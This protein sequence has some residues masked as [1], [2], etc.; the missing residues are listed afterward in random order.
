MIKEHLTDE[1]KVFES[2]GIRMKDT[3][4]VRKMLLEKP[5][6]TF[7]M[8]EEKIQKHFQYH[9]GQ[10]MKTHIYHLLV[11]LMKMNLFLPTLILNYLESTQ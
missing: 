3:D 7:H 10:Y 1:N 4:S 11:I 6:D 2:D 5:E 9:Y 8:F